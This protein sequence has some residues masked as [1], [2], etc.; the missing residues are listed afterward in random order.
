[1]GLLRGR[2]AGAIEIADHADA[3]AIRADFDAAYA[4]RFGL[5]APARSGFNRAIGDWVAVAD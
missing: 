3:D 1:M 2:G 4:S 5:I